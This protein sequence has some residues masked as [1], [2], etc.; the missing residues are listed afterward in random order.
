MSTSQPDKKPPRGL[1][2]TWQDTRWPWKM[3]LAGA[4]MGIIACGL[5]TGTAA[6]F[7][8]RGGYDRHGYIY[9]GATAAVILVST[10][11]MYR[12]GIKHEREMDESD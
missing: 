7:A 5:G 2:K 12:T 8:L 10:V 1:M 6:Y 4:M 9:I 3:A 11:W